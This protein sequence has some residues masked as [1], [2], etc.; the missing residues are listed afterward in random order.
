[1]NPG[2]FYGEKANISHSRLYCWVSAHR[3]FSDH[4]AKNLCRCPTPEKDVRDAV[5][6]IH[7]FISF[8][9]WLPPSL[10][11]YLSL[12]FR[13]IGPRTRKN[14][15][16]SG[17]DTSRDILVPLWKRRTGRSFRKPTFALMGDIRDIVIIVDEFRNSDSFCSSGWANLTPPPLRL[18]GG[19]AHDSHSPLMSSGNNS[20]ASGT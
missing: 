8:A 17:S 10:L 9:H 18:V 3:G 20:S 7:K 15:F 2:T 14:S 1:M 16:R 13:I 19:G 5:D 11:G 12:F 6:P 4:P